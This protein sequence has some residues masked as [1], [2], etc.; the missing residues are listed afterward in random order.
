M[1]IKYLKLFLVSLMLAMTSVA[2][3]GII[4]D[5]NVTNNVIFGSGNSNGSFTVV[6][7]NGIEIGIRGKL[8]HNLSGSPENTFNS[9]GDGTYSFDAGVAPTQS[10]PT[11][12]WS[13]EWSINSDYLNSSGVNLADYRFELSLDID[14][15][16]G[17][18][19]IK[20]DLFQGYFDH[21]IGTNATN[22][23]DGSVAA[24]LADFTTLIANN[25]LAQNS[26]KPHWVLAPFGFDPTLDAL[27]DISIS[28]WSPTQS[29]NPL[30]KNTIQVIVGKG[31][32]TVPEPTTLVIFMFGAL[33]LAVGR[34][35]K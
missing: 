13:Y 12:V 8:R 19:F 29:L 14:P 33:T 7:E 35:K 2:N 32:T 6:Q 31:A 18:N 26:W 1:N 27:Y 3:A 17:V 16:I 21:A 9:N 22:N 11:A 23:G 24:D 34:M 10:A 25:N 15:T 20:F 4:H 28:A 5:A 30:A